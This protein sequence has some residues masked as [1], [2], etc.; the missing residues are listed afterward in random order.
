MTG[1]VDNAFCAI[2]PPGHHAEPNHPKGFCFFNN[3]A[4]AALHARVAHGAER[5]AVV[6]FDAH[7]GNGTQSAFWSD[8]NLF[9]ASTHQM[10]LFPYSGTKEECGVARNIVNAP[11][12]PGDDGRQF[13][14]AYLSII[15]P[16]LHNFAPDLL[17]FSAGF[18][19][20][21]EDPL[22]HLGLVEDD[23]RWVTEEL[24]K[25]AEAHAGGRIVSVLEGG[26]NLKALAS[27][28]AVHV[29]VLMDAAA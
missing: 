10:P 6:D 11:L 5:V 25:I 9:Y 2:R 21:R 19:A 29:R 23:F 18:D 15:L 1:A 7:H 26:Y 13:R 12:R 14:D 17:L 27:S 20:H 28:V 3:I 24:I 4:I 16:A 8:A 22:T